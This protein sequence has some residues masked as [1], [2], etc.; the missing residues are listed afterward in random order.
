MVWHEKLNV[1]RACYCH[2]HMPPLG[3]YPGLLGPKAIPHESVLI[4][5]GSK[6]GL[7]PKN[8][9]MPDPE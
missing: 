4:Q 5:H 1:T 3:L 2:W 6:E 7:N 8:E 9:L